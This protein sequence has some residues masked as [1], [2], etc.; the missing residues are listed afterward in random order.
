MKKKGALCESIK[1]TP[2]EYIASKQPSAEKEKNF[3]TIN[4]D[5][6]TNVSNQKRIMLLLKDDGSYYHYDKKDENFRS[7]GQWKPIRQTYERQMSKGSYKQYGK[8]ENQ[9][10]VK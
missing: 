1:F 2:I 6:I 8:L 3:M 4:N 9:I 5:L 10:Q 7:E